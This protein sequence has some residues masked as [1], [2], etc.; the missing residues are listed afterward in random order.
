MNERSEKK[1]EKE[2]YLETNRSLITDRNNTERRKYSLSSRKSESKNDND[3]DYEAQ[4]KKI[5]EDLKRSN[6]FEKENEIKEEWCRKKVVKSMGLYISK[7]IKL[8]F[9]SNETENYFLMGRFGRT[10]YSNFRVL[11]LLFILVFGLL[12]LFFLLIFKGYT[13][14][15]RLTIAR[16]NFVNVLS[17]LGIIHTILCFVDFYS[18]IEY[19]DQQKVK[20]NNLES[21]EKKIGNT[22]SKKKLEDMKYFLKHGYFNENMS[23]DPEYRGTYI[24][25]EYITLIIDFIKFFLLSLTYDFG[26]KFFFIY[27]ILVIIQ[28]VGLFFYSMKNYEGSFCNYLNIAFD[29][30]ILIFGIKSGFK[31]SNLGIAVIFVPFFILGLLLLFMLFIF[32]GYFF[33]LKLHYVL[34]VSCVIFI[35][36]SISLHGY[37][38]ESTI[39]EGRKRYF[40]FSL[41]FLLL[42]GIIL[43]LFIF[44][45]YSIEFASSDKLRNSKR[46]TLK[47]GASMSNDKKK[48][49][50][51]KND[52]KILKSD[53]NILRAPDVR[54]IK[55]AK[56]EDVS[57]SQSNKNSVHFNK[58]DEENNENEKEIEKELQP[59]KKNIDY[60]FEEIKNKLRSG[61]K[62]SKIEEKEE[63]ESVPK[64][65]VNIKGEMINKSNEKIN[66]PNQD[67]EKHSGENSPEFLDEEDDELNDVSVPDEREFEIEKRIQEKTSPI[68]E[69]PLA[70]RLNIRGRSKSPNKRAETEAEVEHM[71]IGNV[72]E[73]EIEINCTKQ[74]P[75]LNSLKPGEKASVLRIT[76]FKD[77]KKPVKK[78]NN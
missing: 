16:K 40:L 27:Q 8:N 28:K 61:L 5:E 45:Y 4:L 2:E 76:P 20:K 64:E 39:L 72:D 56:S 23:E 54:E 3:L 50:I 68:R 30:A 67:I 11:S 71:E 15:D 66:K 53:K 19:Q 74:S 9:K 55:L 77:R 7:I 13:N 14:L 42:E 17:G 34:L 57:I 69:N 21:Q 24:K 31:N 29:I 51:L 38:D 70:K 78:I 1:I 10:N 73:G 43:T 33:P 41:L 49:G 32:R 25:L 47:N 60:N 48:R 26:I 36:L 46:L 59:E 22:G 62:P 37:F 44:M 18:S 6:F 63:I 12:Y 58:E 52:N 35:A 65:E 75:P